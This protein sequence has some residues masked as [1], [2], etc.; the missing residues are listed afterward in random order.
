M[1]RAAILLLATVVSTAAPGA[2]TV[3][4]V[5]ADPA[6][7]SAVA[8]ARAIPRD[9]DGATARRRGRRPRF[10]GRRVVGDDVDHPVLPDPPLRPVR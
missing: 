10:R 7:A 1:V 8:G 6:S 2:Q 9:A 5:V 3:R 4:G